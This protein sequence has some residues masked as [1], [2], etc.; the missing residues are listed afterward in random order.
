MNEDKYLGFICER[1]WV[2][3]AQIVQNSRL[4]CIKLDIKLY[5][6]QPSTINVINVML[7]SANLHSDNPQHLK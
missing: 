3:L 6:T 5:T 2:K 7:Y 4:N 1:A